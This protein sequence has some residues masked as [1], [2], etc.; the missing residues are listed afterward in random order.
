MEGQLQKQ[1]IIIRRNG[2]PATGT[3]AFIIIICQRDRNMHHSKR[4]H[5]NSRGPF[6]YL[7]LKNFKE[8]IPND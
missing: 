2:K 6:A 1:D 4:D 7:D 5:G 8:V 3:P